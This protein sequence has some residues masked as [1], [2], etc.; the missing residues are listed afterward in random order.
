LK[1]QDAEA[2]DVESQS[3]ESVPWSHRDLNGLD[4]ADA[5]RDLCADEWTD[6]SA[7]R[8]ADLAHTIETEIIPRLIRVHRTT[9]AILPVHTVDA[10]KGGPSLGNGDIAEFTRVVL[11]H[12]PAVAI[13]FIDSLRTEGCSLEK[14][15]LD[16]IAPSAR[17]LGEMWEDDLADFVEVTLA[18][19]RLQQVLHRFSDEFLTE[20]VP[21]LRG[22][23]ILLTPI[24]GDQHTFG[25]IM[26]AEFFRR[27]GWNVM[28]RLSP[29]VGDL[30]DAVREG[31]FEIVGFSANSESR[32]DTLA[33][34]IEALRRA[35]RNPS[36]NVMVGGPLFVARPELVGR[37]GAD[38][39][40]KDG[41]DAVAHAENLSA[42]QS[43]RIR[44][45]AEMQES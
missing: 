43:L 21:P 16:L 15:Y 42:A 25:L 31:W 3:L 20:T 1:Q 4:A 19:G 11:S 14:L 34:S 39:T 6:G 17:R 8:L 32:L 41:M 30:T 13:A 27:A 9:P 26:V 40:A 18:L 7:Q 23:R 12:D 29:S 38:A 2:R 37:V 28:S 35:S 44:A 10:L 33:S 24:P 22:Q 45:C 5:R 36:I